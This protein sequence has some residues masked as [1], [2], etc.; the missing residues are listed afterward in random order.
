MVMSQRA[1][2]AAGSRNPHGLEYRS[3]HQGHGAL[4]R[5][6]R[7]PDGRW[8]LEPQRWPDGHH[9][10]WRTL[11]EQDKPW[12]LRGQDHGTATRRQRHTQLPTDATRRRCL[13]LTVARNCRALSCALV[14]PQFVIG[15][16]PDERA[17][18]VREMALEVA[19]LQAAISTDS[20][21]AHPVSGIS[22]PR[23]RRSSSTST[24][25]SR[26]IRRASSRDSPCVWTS[27]SSGTC[28]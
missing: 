28:A 10:Y 21:S 4:A 25:A 27:G 1:K 23:P 16:L 15:G 3:W 22:S 26:T 14:L 17:T 5:F 6:K 12:L 13:D 11:D 19:L 2:V 18:M 7:H 24:I 20:T 8:G 9:D